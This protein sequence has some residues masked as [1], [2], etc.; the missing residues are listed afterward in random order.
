[1]HDGYHEQQLPAALTQ[2]QKRAL[3]LLQSTKKS[4]NQQTNVQPGQQLKNTHQ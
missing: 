2:H 1:M 3:V 4:T